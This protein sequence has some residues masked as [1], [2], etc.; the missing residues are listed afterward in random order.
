MLNSEK[1]KVAQVF[2]SQ[3]VAV[4]RHTKIDKIPLNVR[5]RG[6]KVERKLLNS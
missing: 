4:H 3:E 1:L 5:Q 6:R 2:E